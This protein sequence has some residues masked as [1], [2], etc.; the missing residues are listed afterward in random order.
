MDL[1]VDA[2][3]A[4]SV[5]LSC[6][7][8][9][10]DTDLPVCHLLPIPAEGVVRWSRL[11][12]AQRLPKSTVEGAEAPQ[13]GYELP[14]IETKNKTSVNLNMTHA[15]QRGEEQ[16]DKL[17]CSERRTETKKEAQRGR[18][19]DRVREGIQLDKSES[20]SMKS[21]SRKRE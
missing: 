5:F 4:P 9:Q 21:P 20:R 16:K 18:G 19:R 3:R 2:Y 10:I 1:P 15:H 17:S 6:S 7:C 12:A 14:E 11:T 8:M 13:V